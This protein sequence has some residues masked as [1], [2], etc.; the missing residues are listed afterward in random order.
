MGSPGEA[1]KLPPE[2][3]WKALKNL[4]WVLSQSFKTYRTWQESELG[5]EL[6]RGRTDEATKGCRIFGIQSQC[7][8]N[9]VAASGGK[10]T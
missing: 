4:C 6:S 3:T 10:K 1:S 9:V 2:R 7:I 8:K 5:E